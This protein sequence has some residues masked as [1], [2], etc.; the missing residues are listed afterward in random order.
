MGRRRSSIQRSRW[1][2][3]SSG[4]FHLPQFNRTILVETFWCTLIKDARWSTI[5]AMP[6]WC[7]NFLR[8]YNVVYWDVFISSVAHNS[9]NRSPEKHRGSHINWFMATVLCS[10]VIIWQSK[11]GLCCHIL[12]LHI[13]FFSS[14]WYVTELHDPYATHFEVLWLTCAVWVVCERL[15]AFDE[16]LILLFGVTWR[17]T[18]SFLWILLT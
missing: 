9:K 7:S 8:P 5:I 14:P 3:H 10:P 11:I 6:C 17:I 12:T 1:R 4:W 15:V 16:P 2:H 13:I 18:I